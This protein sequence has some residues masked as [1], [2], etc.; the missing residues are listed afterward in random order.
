MAVGLSGV[1]RRFRVPAFEPDSTRDVETTGWGI[2]VDLLVPIIAAS[3]E[4]HD[5][6]LT[7]TGSYTRGQGIS[8]L[9][10]ALS[11]PPFPALPHHSNV[12]PA[13]IY[14]ASID[15]GLVGFDS[16]GVLHAVSWQSYIVGLQY[17]FP[18]NSGIWI[19]GTYSRLQSDNVAALSA[20]SRTAFVRSQNA[21]G[22]LF[23]DAAR[24]LR[25]GLEFDW[26]HQDF[27]DPGPSVN[28]R[29]QLSTYYV[30]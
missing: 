2:S 1:L 26:L 22:A 4:R 19:A 17:W 9:Y 11:G 8:D 3:A 21:T 15:R 13:P 27:I 18:G 7:F 25:F 23:W 30:F 29:I 24:A 6:A 14:S 12:T 5:N 20:G 10:T 16:S 28:K